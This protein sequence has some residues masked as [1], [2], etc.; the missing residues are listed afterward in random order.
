MTPIVQ[1]LSLTPKT[2]FKAQAYI[3]VTKL[4]SVVLLTFV[5]FLGGAIGYGLH[6]KMNQG[7]LALLGSTLSVAIA[8]MGANTVTN[9]V[10]RDID[11][12]M[13]RTRNRP[14]PSG[15]IQPPEKALG[16]GIAL[17][18]LSLT[19]QSF[20]SVYGAVWIAIGLLLDIVT[21]N[22]WLKRR[23]PANVVVGS[24]AGGAPIMAVWSSTVGEFWSLM[25]ILM[26]S[27]VVLWTPIHIWSLA[28]RYSDDY[29]KAKVPML[30]VVIG[31][32]A[33]IRCIAYS[34]LLLVVFTTLLFLIIKVETGFLFAGIALNILVSIMGSQLA[35]NPSDKN[36]WRL[37]KFTSPYLALVFLILALSTVL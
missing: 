13:V 4:K 9:Y 26:A 35:L 19:L 37:F 28:I 14:I 31:K 25:P 3:E 10:D 30:P 5:G 22:V 36:A 29:V 12:L 24:M 16:Y 7:L 17:I 15:K 20:F 33:A 2:A 34:S 6:P 21:Y 11:A 23:S 27:L 8:C 1:L 32:K 18:S